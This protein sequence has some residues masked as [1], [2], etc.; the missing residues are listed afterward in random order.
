M[1]FGE[2]LS[3]IFIPIIAWGAYEI[4]RGNYKKWYILSIGLGLLVLSHLITS[5]FTI[6]TLF[7]FVIFNYKCLFKEKERIYAFV[8]AGIVVVLLSVYEILPLLEQL[9]YMDFFLKYQNEINPPG[10]HK[11]GLLETLQAFFVGLKVEDKNTTYYMWD[12]GCGFILTILIAL[13]L[14]VKEKNEKIR[15]ADYSLLIGFVFVLFTTKLAPWGRFPLNLLKDIQFPWRLFEY[16]TFFFAVAG[17]TYVV[18]LAT[19]K[20]RKV[21]AGSV[22]FIA[23]IT[24][25]SINAYNFRNSHFL[26]GA[27]PVAKMS[28]NFNLGSFEYVP[29]KY[30]YYT[31]S[32]WERIDRR[33]DEVICQHEE[34]EISN[35]VHEK[36]NIRFHIDT[37]SQVDSIM[38]PLFLYKGYEATF[39]G[40]EVPI[41]ESKMGL[42]ELSINGKGEVNVDFEGTFIQKY[43]F[44]VTLFTFILLTVYIYYVSR[45]RSHRTISDSD[46]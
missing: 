37:K 24:I 43:S 38:V 40:K 33:K 6:L 30:V 15:M 8:K 44:Y 34:T 35:Y 42:V 46:L 21:L 4:I 22:I 27:T 18:S 32:F 10:Q 31:F 28:N 16:V 2:T 12:Q 17:A 26:K 36:S 7:V 14:F 41:A 20:K 13:R 3:Y 25:I 9:S 29:A 23:T 11:L 1:A 39:N 5:V 45:S 19:T